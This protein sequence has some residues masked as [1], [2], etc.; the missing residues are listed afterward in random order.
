MTGNGLCVV[1]AVKGMEQAPK[2]FQSLYMQKEV[3]FM[4]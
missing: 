4:D 1:V 2:S 3:A